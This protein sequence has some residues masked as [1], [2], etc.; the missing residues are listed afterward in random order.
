MEDCSAYHL[1]E[2]ELIRDTANP[3]RLVPSYDCAGWTV[4]DIGCGIG[5]TLTAEELAACASLHGLDVDRAAI[6][7]GR[8]A[9]PHLAL[10][11]GSA[12][13]IPYP[14]EKFDLVFSRVALPYTNIPLA[15]R[16]MHRVLK[17]GGAVWL[18]LHDW[19]MERIQI[20][21]ALRARNLRR[22]LD[23]LYVCVNSL[24]LLLFSKCLRRPWAPTFE[25]FQT[26]SGIE[27]LLRDAGFASSKVR[28]DM[29]FLVT[30]VK[31]AGRLSNSTTRSA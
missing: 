3:K 22:L 18:T 26:E 25:T 10:S 4:L 31:P 12:E 16:E 23:R 15:L 13:A 11:L 8:R 17:P 29:H 24:S 5:Q 9:F 19:K 21:N 7:Y 30:A 14:A 20:H 27:R 1:A 6:D 2:L 28:H